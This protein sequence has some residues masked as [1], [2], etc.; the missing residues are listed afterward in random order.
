MQKSAN[1][2]SLPGLLLL[3]GCTR[4]LPEA[5]LTVDPDM[6]T[7][8]AVHLENADVI[9]A[10][11]EYGDAGAPEELWAHTPDQTGSTLDF[12]VY[13]HASATSG[14]RVVGTDARDRAISGPVQEIAID[15]L[16]S[17][18]PEFTSTIDVTLDGLGP[19]LLTSA[20][21]AD[22]TE[23]AVT[24]HTVDGRPVWYWQPDDGVIPSVRYD[25]ASGTLY[26]VVF[27]LP[28]A[29]FGYTFQLPVAGGDVVKH[30]LTGVHHD[31]LL[32]EDGV[33]A[34]LVTSFDDFEGEEIAGDRIVEIDPD[35]TERTVWDAFD[36]LTP[37]EN[38]AWNITPYP[39]GQP[40]WTH[41]NGLDYD[42]VEGAY[43]LSLWGPE[44]I[45][46]V[47]RATGNTVWIMGGTENEFDFGDDVGFGPQH[48]PDFEDGR[49]LLFDNRGAGGS[50]ACDFVVDETA[51]TATLDWSFEPSDPE[52]ALVLGDVTER[53]DGSHLMSWGSAGNIFVTA[54]D[55]EL[56]GFLQ[57]D[58]AL[59]VGQVSELGMLP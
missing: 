25:V 57:M 41:A 19:F 35:G 4:T 26:G 49:L 34:T 21:S 1:S 18:I 44:Q 54:A 29:G 9:T 36:Y 28:N 27:D 38:H 5:T 7:R 46:K 42:P 14:I 51:R 8:V 12:T 56:V 32:L 53:A 17:G 31:A 40:D 47:D 52:W 13:L 30:E 50:R 16:P 15:D 59:A 6:V 37:A 20:M 11:A 39:D 33:M 24:I 45:I 58:K 10:H 48:A 2:L 43:Y 23:T 55:D 3:A 22:P